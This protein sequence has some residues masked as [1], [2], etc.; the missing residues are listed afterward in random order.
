MAQGK[1]AS[2]I[3]M[4][5]PRSLRRSRDEGRVLVEQWRESGLRP[6]EFCRAGG[7]Q[8]TDCTTGSGGCSSTRRE[9]GRTRRRFSR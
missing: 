9:R 2:T 3:E 6:A 7:S 8:S 5:G 1:H 4:E